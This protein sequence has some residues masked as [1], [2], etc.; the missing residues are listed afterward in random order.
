MQ[1]RL[2]L[3]RIA[4]GGALALAG[5]GDGNS[6]AE[7]TSTTA[8]S[9]DDVGAGGGTGDGDGAGGTDDD[10]TATGGTG[11]GSATT[12]GPTESTPTKTVETTTDGP[13]T[14]TLGSLDV[15]FENNYRYRMDFSNYQPQPVDLTLN[16]EWNGGAYHN[17]MTHQGEEIDIWHV[18]GTFTMRIDGYCSTFSD[19][20]N[21]PVPD[22]N[23]DEWA[24]TSETKAQVSDWADL[25]AS[26]QTT[27]D[28]DQLWVFEVAAGERGNEYAYTYYVSTESGYIRR[29]E[30]QGIVAEYWDWGAVGPISAPC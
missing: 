9:G 2:F 3:R 23:S 14:P 25:Q 5:C 10:G 4:A 6:L 21:I 8:E 1:R 20:T 29:I 13:E 30:T 16:G 7:T 24:D 12:A 19:E 15:S 28:G 27:I 17:W 22:L 11:D 26:G 18:G